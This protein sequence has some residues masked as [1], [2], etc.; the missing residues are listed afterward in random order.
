MFFILS[1]LLTVIVYPLPLLLLGLLAILVFYHRRSA[2]WLLALVLILFYVLSVPY[3]V[4]PL[5]QW[6]EGPRPTQ[7]ALRPHYD[8]AIMLTG[9]VYLGVSSYDHIEFNE[10]VE[11]VLTGV[12]FVKRGIADKL[13]IVG[14]SGSLSAVRGSEAALLRTFVLEFGLR[15]EQVLTEQTSRNTYENAVYAAEI[16]RA[17]QYRDLVLITSALHIQRAAA[18]FHKQGLFP[19]LYP[20]D[21]QSSDRRG[22]VFDFYPSPK[23]LHLATQV[24]HEWI[25]RVMYR[26]QGYI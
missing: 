7:E 10:H 5:V 14:G 21:F 24:M 26:L 25:G 3:A 19:D 17:G 13:L 22:N 16:I 9:I 6:L 20:V 11:R 18:A 2:R 4:L 8:V 1:K 12:S 23:I 15:D